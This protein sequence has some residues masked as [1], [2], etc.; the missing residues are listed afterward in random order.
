MLLFNAL[1]RIFPGWEVCGNWGIRYNRVHEKSSRKVFNLSL[2][3][4]PQKNERT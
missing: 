4:E 3:K 1:N 2:S